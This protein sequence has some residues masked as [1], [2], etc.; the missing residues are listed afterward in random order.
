MVCSYIGAGGH[1]VNVYYIAQWQ[2][3]MSWTRKDCSSLVPRQGIWHE[4]KIAA[5]ACE[6]HLSTRLFQIM[7]YT[8]AQVI[9]HSL[10]EHIIN[11]KTPVGI[12]YFFLTHFGFGL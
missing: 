4:T 10:Q 3:L 8:E 12:L 7:T 6:P 9:L 11:L 1:P 2:S 5:G